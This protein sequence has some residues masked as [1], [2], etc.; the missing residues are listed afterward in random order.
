FLT[1]RPGESEP[2][3]LPEDK[4]LPLPLEPRRL[5][6]IVSG[7]RDEPTWQTSAN[8]DTSP[9]DF[10]DLKGVIEDMLAGLHVRSADFAAAPH[11]MLHP[12][13]AAVLKLGETN[14]GVL[15]ELHPV[16]SERWELPNQPILVGE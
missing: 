7:P 13:R 8:A 16:V 9:M 2:G 15:G 10:Y 1:R 6:F 5:G 12:G 4:G 3:D 11:P 14:V